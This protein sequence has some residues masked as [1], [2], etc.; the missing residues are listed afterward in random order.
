MIADQ[1]T[2]TYAP[3][4]SKEYKSTE[5]QLSD[6]FFQSSIP[7]DELLENSFLFMTTQHIKRTLFFY[8]I[9]KKIVNVPGVVMHFGCRWG[10]HIALFDSLRT[11]FE[12]FNYGRKI[13]GFETFSGFPDQFDN[14]K[15][16]NSKIMT[17][18]YLAT[19]QGYEQELERILQA[20]EAMAPMSHI[21][22]YEIIKGDVTTTFPEYMEKN[23]HTIVAFAHLDINLFQPTKQSLEI[24]KRHVT[25]GSIIAI[26]EVSFDEIPGQTL[27]LTEVFG[28]NNIR[29]ERIPHVNP[30][31]PAYFVID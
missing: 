11:I 4:K 12:P 22:K 14:E 8:E 30:T 23:P 10:R 15:D 6:Y 5:Q 18:G 13:I 3:E 20:R 21:K 7:K 9:Y 25:K 17:E 2:I 27:A 1:H 31:W 29:L 19:T 16:K 24:L 28:L 26:D